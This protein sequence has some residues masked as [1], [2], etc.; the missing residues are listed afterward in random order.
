MATSIADLK[1]LF[2][3]FLANGGD[4]SKLQKSLKGPVLVKVFRT[5][6]YVYFQDKEFYVTGYFTSKALKKL[7]KEYDLPVRDLKS[8]TLKLEKFTLSFENADPSDYNPT[9]YLGKE[10]RIIV[11][12]FSLS[13][14]LKRGKDVNKYIVNLFRDEQ[15]KLAIAQTIHQGKLKA[16]EATAFDDFLKNEVKLP[17]GNDYQNFDR[18]HYDENTVLAVSKVNSKPVDS[19][20][21]L[22]ELVTCI[23]D[24]KYDPKISNKGKKR[25]SVKKEVK[26]EEVQEAK[27]ELLELQSIQSETADLPTTAQKPT[28]AKRSRK[29]LRPKQMNLEKTEI[30]ETET[31]VNMEHEFKTEIEK[32]LQYSKKPKSQPDMDFLAQDQIKEI[33][34]PKPTKTKKL[35]HFREYMEWYDNKCNLGKASVASRGVSTNLSTPL[36]LSLRISERLASAQKLR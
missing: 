31:K 32:I 16:E 2:M 36:K 28:K 11:D 25:R 13:R 29:A 7:Q 5:E 8:K 14:D 23:V 27:E 33:K 6:P 22:P 20:F 15:V 19:R 17:I 26:E 12:D 10:V 4:F 34:M 3:A 30:K 24:D 21:K 35:S 18:V 1:G 9:N